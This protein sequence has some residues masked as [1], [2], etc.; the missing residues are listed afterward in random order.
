MLRKSHAVLLMFATIAMA[1]NPAGNPTRPVSEAKVERNGAT[2]TIAARAARP[3]DRALIALRGEYGWIVDY[4]DPPYDSHDLVDSTDPNWRQAHPN[5]KGVTRVAGGSF[6]TAFELG[7]GAT[8]ESAEGQRA[9]GQ[10]VGDYNRSGNPGKFVIKSEGL[11]R[12]SVVG[13]AANESGVSETSVTPILDTRIAIPAGE[14]GVAEAIKRILR[15]VSDK[16][17]E[18]ITLGSGPVN[19]MFHAKVNLGDDEQPARE[20]LAQAA[21]VTRFPL[22]WRLLYSADMHTYF[23]NCESTAHMASAPGQTTQQPP[24]KP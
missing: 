23:L 11:Q 4:E 24:R 8:L 17:G 3:L 18:K 13:V 22:V 10:V 7:G 9:L 1:Q 6:T 19:L 20:L 21:A 16:S 14:Y 12:Y 15:V 5:A 2:V